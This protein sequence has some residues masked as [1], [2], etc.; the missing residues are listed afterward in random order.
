MGTVGHQILIFMHQ[1]KYLCSYY[2]LFTPFFIEEI[3]YSLAGYFF[4]R[5]LICYLSAELWTELT[6]LT[7]L[8]SIYL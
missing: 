6:C 2:G 5:G 4:P 3:L 1:Y 7:V 8:K